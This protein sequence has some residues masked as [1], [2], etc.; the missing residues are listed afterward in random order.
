MLKLANANQLEPIAQ[1]FNSKGIRA[2]VLN[3]FISVSRDD[4]CRVF[5]NNKIP[6][7]K[8]GSYDIAL[9]SIRHIIAGAKVVCW[10]GK[11]DESLFL[12]VYI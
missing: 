6:E 7:E 2:E 12:E 10:C 1:C 9:E 5:S 3:D 8:G 11:T 4:M